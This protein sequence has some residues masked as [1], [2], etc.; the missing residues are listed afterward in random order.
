[1]K[2]GTKVIFKKSFTQGYVSINKGDRLVV[3]HYCHKYWVDLNTL[4]GSPPVSNLIRVPFDSISECLEVEKPHF[5]DVA[6]DKFA[7]AMKAKLEQS[8]QKGR[9][10]W[11]SSE[12]CSTASLEVLL[13]E[14]VAAGDPIDIANYAMM[15]FHRKNL[16]TVKNG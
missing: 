2:F 15:I 8:R 11:N 7:Q 13:A 9:H 5:D 12:F 6:V 10:G 3:A 14:Q 1:M 4:E 16:E